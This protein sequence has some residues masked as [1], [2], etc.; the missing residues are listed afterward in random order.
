LI[1]EGQEAEFLTF[2]APQA[3]ILRILEVVGV[4]NSNFF[5]FPNFR[6]GGKSPPSGYALA[7]NTKSSGIGLG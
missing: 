4:K 5:H 6:G 7:W 3:K 1:L 2:S